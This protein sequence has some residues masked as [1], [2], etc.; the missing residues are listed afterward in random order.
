MTEEKAVV[1]I[2]NR[3]SP[4]WILPIV[5]L[6]L[7]MWAVVYSL[8]QQG[9]EIE[10]RFETAAGLIEGKTKLKYLDVDVGEVENIRF[11]EDREAVI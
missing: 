7:G 2:G 6:V 1:S 8:T 4:V 3:L 11:T 9:P 5:A 10:I